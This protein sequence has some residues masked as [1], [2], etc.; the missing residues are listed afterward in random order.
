[1]IYQNLFDQV[2]KP[3][4]VNAGIIGC[5]SFGSAIV[6]QSSIVPRLR[7]P[8]VADV[9][10][11]AGRSAFLQA[12]IEK[13]NIVI[14]DNHNSAICAIEKG[15]SV[16]V[17][18]GT[19]L[20]DLPL[21]VIVTSTRVAEAGAFYAYE[22]IQNHKHVV[23]VDKEADSVVGPILKHL[24][25]K[26]G[27]V[28]TTDD[29]DQP[30]LL[31]G[32]VS[33]ARSI[34]LEVLCGGHLHDCI[35]DPIGLTVKQNGR[36]VKIREEDKW[37]FE[38]ILAGKAQL[39]YDARRQILADLLQDNDDGDTICHLVVASN[40]TGLLPDSPIG[41]RPVAR[42]TELPEV[43]CP[44]EEGG[45]LKTRGAVDIPVILR[46]VNEPHGGGGVFIIVTNSNAHSRNI[47][48]QKGLFAN[49]RGSAMLIYRPHHLCGAET[50][51]S[52]LCAGLLKIPTGSSELVP[53][54]DMV[55]KA[56]RDFKA[57]EVLGEK[58]GS[59]GLNLELRALLVP[60]VSITNDNPLP[61]FM[62][63]NKKLSRDIISGT[64]ITKDMIVPP[65]GSFLW[66]LRKQQDEHFLV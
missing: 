56:S 14:C 12:G 22:A 16:V 41:H 60:A 3:E 11:E 40:G 33:W 65:K 47:M 38:P 2:K 44:I 48:I 32:L 5:G 17:Q 54:I 6:T 51:V 29:G 26:A 62:L 21:D 63:E 25:D 28:Y 36:T 15:K 20:M 31:M 57:G 18:D 39:Y 1:M 19:I 45:I 23:M 58:P 66:S 13:D 8:I 46:T 9:N 53:R 30:G 43:L 49:S 24:A 59:L 10:V 52:I 50:A 64:I 42:F 4:F 55:A 61:F 7:I 34:G 35:Y 37:A 27:V